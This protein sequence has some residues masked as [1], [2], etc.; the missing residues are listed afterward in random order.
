MR[1]VANPD[2][3]NE[4]TF[5]KGENFKVLDNKGKWWQVQTQAGKV[6]IVPSNYVQL[7]Q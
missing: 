1:I 2:D 3:P 5:E 6:G 7:V 4:L